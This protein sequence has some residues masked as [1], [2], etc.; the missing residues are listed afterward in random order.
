MFSRKKENKQKG[1]GEAFGSDGCVALAAPPWSSSLC[2]GPSH[3]PALHRRY[4]SVSAILI[5]APRVLAPQGGQHTFSG[6]SSNDA[7]VT[8]KCPLFFAKCS[9]NLGLAVGFLVDMLPEPRIAFVHCSW[10]IMEDK[11]SQMMNSVSSRKVTEHKYR[12]QSLRI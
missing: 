2:M 11:P 1:L 12:T 3:H 10:V 4:E 5:D 9:L 8:T 7:S 6:S